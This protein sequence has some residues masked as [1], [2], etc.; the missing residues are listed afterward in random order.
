MPPPPGPG[1]PESARNTIAF[2]PFIDDGLAL[3]AGKK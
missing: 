1:S 2:K 3:A